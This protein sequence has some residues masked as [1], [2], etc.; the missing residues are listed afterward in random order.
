MPVVRELTTRLGYDIQD[1][2]LRKY[3][4]QLGKL[5]TNLGSIAT[6]AAAA[7]VALAAIGA[8]AFISKLVSTNIEFENLSASL[9]TA[10]GS[11]EAADVAFAKL[12]EFAATTPFAL[13][14]SVGAFIKLKNL[15]IEPTEARLRSFGNTASAMGKS[16]DQFIEAVADASTGEF[17]RLK[18]FGI[19]S[20]K[21]GDKVA[22]TFR[23][24]TTQV[25]NDSESISNFLQNIGETT[26]AGAMAKRAKTLGG[27]IS[28]LKDGITSFFV[29]AGQAGSN[30]ALKRL[31]KLLGE[32]VGKSGDLATNIGSALGKGLDLIS[33]LIEFSIKWKDEIAEASET[34][35]LLLLPFG[36]IMLVVRDIQTLLSGGDSLTESIIGKAGADRIRE[37]AHRMEVLIDELPKIMG[38]FASEIMPVLIE[39]F[40]E[41][42]PLVAEIFQLGK[43]LVTEVFAALIDVGDDQSLP[44]MLRATIPIIKDMI[45]GLVKILKVMSAITIISL[46]LAIAF[47]RF[48][49]PAF[50]AAQEAA[51]NFVTKAIANIELLIETASS[52]LSTLGGAVDTVTGAWDRMAGAI[53]KVSGLISSVP[54]FLGGPGGSSA[55]AAAPASGGQ[56]LLGGAAQSVTQSVGAMIF[57]VTGNTSA[58]PDETA[59][60]ISSAVGGALKSQFADANRNTLGAIS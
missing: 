23:G 10:T 47:F 45:I 37:F 39:A 44:D 51:V 17:E 42:S 35:K 20:K 27:I 59:N 50:V 14:E 48:V 26:F 31:L 55:A 30:D 9:E 24:V 22:F 7:A 41:L 1:A 38:E 2:Q 40:E 8:T 60:V 36:K 56:S 32:V 18:E 3:D 13:Q 19:K 21:E 4:G 46:K 43:Q 15:G 6:A 29:T 54:Q 12:R 11:A 28:N 33:D 49:K 53:S 5:A 34:A 52:V 16:L 57:N 58:S 25:K